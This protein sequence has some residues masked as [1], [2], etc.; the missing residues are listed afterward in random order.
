MGPGW[1]A[2]CE[3]NDDKVK[4]QCD[5]KCLDKSLSNSELYYDYASVSLKPKKN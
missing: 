3:C 5:A 4:Y 2:V 1:K